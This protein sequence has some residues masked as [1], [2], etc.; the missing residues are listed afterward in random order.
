MNRNLRIYNKEECVIFRKTNGKY[1]GLSNMAP[2]YPIKINN[3]IIYTSEALYQCFRFTH[4]SEVQKLII[5][6]KNPMK[7][8]MISRSYTNQTR[9]DWNIIRINIMRWVLRAKLLC[10]L[11]KFSKLLMDTD[12]KFIV[13]ES[14][15]DDFW[16]AIPQEDGR[17]VGVN[18]LGRL[19]MELREQCKNINGGVIGLRPLQINDFKI[20]DKYVN[21][22]KI[23]TNDLDRSNFKN[24][25]I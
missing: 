24:C 13:E 19:L 7:A 25:D 1:G 5:S 21:S 8:K 14:F 9:N 2:G 6:E 16:G 4:L 18:A 20:L 15:K 22:I 3:V 17:L 10:N 11:E 23:N 12:G